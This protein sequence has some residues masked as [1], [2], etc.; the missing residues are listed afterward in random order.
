[1]GYVRILDRKDWKVKN[2]NSTVPCSYTKLTFEAVLK[3]CARQLLHMVLWETP[4]SIIDAMVSQLFYKC[5]RF[6]L[7]QF[8][9]VY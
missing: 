5:M 7:R 3:L 8:I 2:I 9:L 4:W 6:T 1:M